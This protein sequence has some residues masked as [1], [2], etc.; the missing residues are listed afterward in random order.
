MARYVRWADSGRSSELATL[1]ADDGVLRTDADE[2]RGR[3]AIA[4]YLETQ[5][6]S[7][8][9]D[10]GRIR[11]HVSSVRIDLDDEDHARAVS[12]FLALTAVGLDHW[13]TYRDRLERIDG[14]WRFAERTARVEG[15]APGSWAESRRADPGVGSR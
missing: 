2:V 3:D 1:F 11:H 15:S 7:L 12:Y 14:R 6:A 5:K 13:G 8:A 10:G 9:G 4:S